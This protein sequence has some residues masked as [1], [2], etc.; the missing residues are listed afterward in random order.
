MRLLTLSLAVSLLAPHIQAQDKRASPHETITGKVNGKTVT[1]AYG[2]PSLKGRKA[3]GG[4]L[5]PFGKVWRTGA[6]EATV[7]TTDADLQ[8]GTLTVPKG[9]YTLFTI[10]GE[11]EWT[12][13]VNKK[14]KQWGAFE[15]KEA[16][17]LGRTPM[18][19]RALTTPVEQFTIAVRD[20][21]LVMS[22]E[23]T[24]ASVALK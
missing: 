10:P 4:T 19:V 13:I 16:E 18:K 21:Q 7:L 22:W 17:D 5:A 15:Y 8:V 3:V 20:N 23:N 1:I 14:A 2:R 6:D 11:K 12:L 9:S 24:E